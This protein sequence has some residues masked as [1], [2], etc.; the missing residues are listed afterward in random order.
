MT[1]TVCPATADGESVWRELWRAFLAFHKTTKPTEIHALSWAWMRDWVEH[2]FSRLANFLYHHSFWQPVDR[3]YLNGLFASPPSGGSGAS[4]ALV[5][6]V[7]SH[8]QGRN[9][10]SVY[11]LTTQDNVQA[12][13]LYDPAAS[14]TPFVKYRV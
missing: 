6:V 2:L 7:V 14:L 5:D 8:A 10:A 13:R 12:R 11:W 9:C 1:V 3:Y 4:F